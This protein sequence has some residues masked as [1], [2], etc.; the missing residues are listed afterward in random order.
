M[1]S[2]TL[3]FV[4]VVDIINAFQQFG[5]IN[6]MTQGGPVDSTN[7][8]VYSIYRDAFFNFRFGVASA[9]SIILFVILLILTVLQFKT[10]ERRVFYR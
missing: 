5:V 6:I 1:L 10:G 4:T 7:V 9:E 2:P 8:V 3:F